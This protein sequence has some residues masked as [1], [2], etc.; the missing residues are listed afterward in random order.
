MPKTC[1]MS[2]KA[3]I[4]TKLTA[5]YVVLVTWFLFDTIVNMGILIHKH[6]TVAPKQASNSSTQRLVTC[7]GVR[8][9]GFGDS[10]CGS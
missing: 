4:I 8:I 6:R 10:G 7:S 9:H 2:K 1:S 5:I 3:L